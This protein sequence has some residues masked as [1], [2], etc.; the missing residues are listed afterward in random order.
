MSTPKSGYLGDDGD[1]QVDPV[2]DMEKK[3]RER[4]WKQVRRKRYKV[5]VSI[6]AVEVQ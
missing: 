3:R 1:V 5:G 4:K 2:L 6:L